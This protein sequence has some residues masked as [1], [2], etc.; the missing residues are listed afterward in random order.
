MN[1]AQKLRSSWRNIMGALLDSGYYDTYRE[2]IARVA[3]VV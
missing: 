1:D 2:D 3:G